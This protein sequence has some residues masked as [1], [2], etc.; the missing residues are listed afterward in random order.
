M[1]KER[2]PGE[3]PKNG[4]T[5]T[6]QVTKGNRRPRERKFELLWGSTNPDSRNSRRWFAKRQFKKV[7]AYDEPM[8]KMRRGG[9]TNAV[10]GS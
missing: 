9:L 4:T 8:R 3:L 5:V 10:K 7:G 6:Q 2:G 1:T